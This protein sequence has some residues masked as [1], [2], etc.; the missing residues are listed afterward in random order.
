[1]PIS[2]FVLLSCLPTMSRPSPSRMSRSWPDEQTEGYR[3]G[4]AVGEMLIIGFGKEQGPPVRRQR[5]ESRAAEGELLCHFVPKQ[6]A[7]PGRHLRQFR[8]DFGG[9]GSMQEVIE[10]GR[11]FGGCGE[12]LAGR[13]HVALQAD[14]RTDH[15]AVAPQAEGVAIV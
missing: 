14:N 9:I 3:L 15:L 12:R 4:I 5:G 11:Q 1:M 10:E 7:E 8:A 13:Y 6:A 2:E